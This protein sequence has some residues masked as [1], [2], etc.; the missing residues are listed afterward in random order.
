MGW[1][2]SVDIPLLQKEMVSFFSFKK[3]ILDRILMDN[4][5]FSFVLIAI[6]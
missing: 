3:D 6:P 1:K 4:S 2:V 5:S